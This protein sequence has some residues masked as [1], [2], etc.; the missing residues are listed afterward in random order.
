MARLCGLLLLLVLSLAGG[1]ANAGWRE[2][3][4]VLRIGMVATGAEPGAGP[5]YADALG[6]ALG[7]RVEYLG[8]PDFPALIEAQ[9][10]GRVDY[11]VYTATAYAAA[12]ALCAC[13][14][15]V[16]APTDLDGARGLNAVLIGRRG[17]LDG[18]DV[19]GGR[20]VAAGPAASLPLALFAASGTV[21]GGK[22]VGRDSAFL[23]LK[24]SAE[25]ALAMFV[26]GDA[27]GLIGWVASDGR[28]D[29]GRGTRALAI[30]AG[31]PGDGLSE[32]WRSGFLR[33]GPHAVRRTLP[34]EAKA[35]IL[36]FLA[37][38]KDGDAKLYEL[39]EPRHGGGFQPAAHKDY[40]AAAGIA[41]AALSP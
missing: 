5:R 25:E 31:A 21:V 39:V 34:A 17:R 37:A 30:Q 4:G 19:L 32:I 26:R 36:A 13:I 10:A 22:P 29:L 12:Y 6:N 15:P 20:K 3:L 18:L 16:A 33:F 8:A 41:D 27:D 35:A 38:L 9:A 28:A 24:G 2:D 7:L 1:T 23:A 14:E 40:A 11:A